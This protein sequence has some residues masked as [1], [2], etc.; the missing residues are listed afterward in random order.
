MCIQ[1]LVTSLPL[2]H[3]IPKHPQP[4]FFP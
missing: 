2:S 4:V 1:F 3:F